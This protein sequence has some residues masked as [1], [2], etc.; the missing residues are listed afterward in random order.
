MKQEKICLKKGSKCNTGSP[1]F[2]RQSWKLVPKTFLTES[3]EM[4]P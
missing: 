2:I 4:P 1:C 3:K